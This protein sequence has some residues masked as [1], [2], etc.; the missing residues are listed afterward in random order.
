MAREHPLICPCCKQVVPPRLF[1]PKMLQR[2]YDC[3]SRHPAGVTRGQLMDDIYSDDPN[4]GPEGFSVISVHV[5][6]LNKR[7]EQVDLRIKG[8]GGPGSVFRLQKR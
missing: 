5:M 8:T 3:V 7:L 6:R 4:G 1:L 2:I